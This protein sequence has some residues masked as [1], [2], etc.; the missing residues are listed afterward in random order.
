MSKKLIILIIVAV[1]VAGGAAY[2][3]YQWSQVKFC[4]GGNCNRQSEIVLQGDETANWKTYRNEKYGFEVRYPASFTG[5]GNLS[6]NSVLG[7]AQNPLGGFYI[8]YLVFVILDN[9]AGKKKANDYLSKYIDIAKNPI[10]RIEGGSHITCEI[11]EVPDSF[12]DVNAVYCSPA[13]GVYALI[14]GDKYDIFVDG[15]SGGYGNV[16]E[17]SSLSR[18]D[19]PNPPEDEKLLLSTFRFI[20]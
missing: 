18:F 9:E 14:K 15:Y 16:E 19:N 5:V 4:E 17:L 2:W 3:Y 13:G 20:E 1:V 12:V 11:V 7:S 8:G 10:E 6:Q